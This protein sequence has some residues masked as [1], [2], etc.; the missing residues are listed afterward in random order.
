[1]QEGTVVGGRIDDRSHH[2]CEYVPRYLQPTDR[3]ES[4]YMVYLGTTQYLEVPTYG[5]Y[6]PTTYLLTHVMS[7]HHMLRLID[8]C[9]ATYPVK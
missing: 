9:A 3:A 6:L 7:R 1:M 4:R 8:R 5:T 2:L